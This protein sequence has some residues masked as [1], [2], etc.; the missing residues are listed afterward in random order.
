VFNL[1][2][3][4]KHCIRKTFLSDNDVNLYIFYQ[5][6]IWFINIIKVLN[7]FISKRLIYWTIF[8]QKHCMNYIGYG[9]ISGLSINLSANIYRNVKNKTKNTYK[10]FI[11]LLFLENSNINIWWK[12]QVF[13]VIYFWITAIQNKIISIMSKTGV[14]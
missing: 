14:A 8:Y 12:C 1:N 7:D 9:V 4:I 10:E 2:K 13:T 6:K 11:I 5:D 3:I